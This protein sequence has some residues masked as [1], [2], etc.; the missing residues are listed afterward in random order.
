MN[1]K[2]L[3][4]AV[5]TVSDTRTAGDDTSGNLLAESLAHAGHYCRKRE[6]V[7]DNVYQIRRVLSDWIADD[8]IQVIITTGGTGFSHRDSTPEAVLPLL[9]RR[10][11]GFGE[12]FRQISYEEIGSS[13]IQSRAFAGMANHTLIFC[14]P[15]SNHACQTA[16]DRILREQ[17]DSDHKPCNFAS[18][19]DVHAQS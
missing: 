17:L 1:K 9:D 12:L 5:L 19:F 2:Y 8:T 7:K 10:I 16:W 3:A 4:C 13:T 11:D 14:L 15:G 6:I 18:H